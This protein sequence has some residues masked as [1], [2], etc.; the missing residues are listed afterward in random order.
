MA[1]YVIGKST[2]AYVS[3]GDI[4]KFEGDAIVTPTNTQGINNGG[5]D[6]DLNAAGGR[7]L[8]EARRALPFLKGSDTHR[9]EIGDAGQQRAACFYQNTSYVP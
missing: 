8:V 1:S 7:E 5:I 9:I 4:L 6:E 2:T 3:K